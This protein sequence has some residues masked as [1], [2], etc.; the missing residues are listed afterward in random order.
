M[1]DSTSVGTFYAMRIQP[2]DIKIPEDDPFSNDLLDRKKH[3]EVLTRLIDSIEGPCVLAIDAEWG[4]GKTTFLE[5]W[6]QSLRNQDYPVV[7]FNAWENDHV[8]DPLAAISN[9]LTEE[10]NKLTDEKIQAS[11][12][13]LMK[14]AEPLARSALDLGSLLVPVIDVF[15]KAA[16]PLWNAY[17]NNK[18]AVKTFK[19]TLNDLAKA[20]SESKEGQPVI[21][22]IDELDRCRPS[23]AVELLEIAKHLFSVDHIVFILA[24]NRSQLEH[25]IK[26]IYGSGFDAH[27][28]LRR[29]IDFDYMLPT[30]DRHAFINKALE[31]ANLKR[32]EELSNHPKTFELY[33]TEHRMLL[34]F[35]GTSH[36][37]LREIQQAINRLGVVHSFLSNFQQGKAT[38]MSAV[39]IL[40]TIDMDLYHEFCY[41]D[42]KY[43][44]VIND[45]FGGPN[46][47]HIKDLDEGLLFEAAILSGY[48]D[49]KGSKD[50]CDDVLAGKYMSEM[51]E[52]RSTKLCKWIKWILG[53][54]LYILKEGKRRVPVRPVGFRE[55][56]ELLDRL[57]N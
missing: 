42:A 52:D 28:Y 11:I 37:S 21:I 32:Y 16:T 31:T 51:N 36:I 17:K 15:N 35:L 48:F 29:F 47:N 44:K 33:K 34:K 53:K 9:E 14:H 13:K 55:S 4:F 6:H 43:D 49:L 46:Y 19:N 40:R 50:I 54:D 22:M 38:M 25:T 1:G 41:Q 56:I 7:S 5:M 57:S 12:I 27:G 39:F 20:V 30:P 10:L 24:I 2:R 45:I 8:S 26:S 3:V 23:Y 18:D